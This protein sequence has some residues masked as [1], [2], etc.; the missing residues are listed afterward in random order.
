MRFV[1][2]LGS[3]ALA[4]VITLPVY[5]QLNTDANVNQRQAGSVRGKVIDRDGKPIQNA[6]IRFDNQT[7]HQADT[8]KTNKSGDYSIVGLLAGS[9]KAYLFVDGK[10]VMVK[11]EGVGNQIL[12]NDVT[13]TRVNFD[14]KD[15]PTTRVEAPGAPSAA[16]LNAKEKAAAEKKNIEEVKNSYAAGLAAMKA[17]NFEEAIKL[18]QVAADKDPG[19]SAVFANMGVSYA[20]L[21]KYDDAIAAYQKS[22]AIKPDDPSIHALLSLALANNGKIDE[23]TQSA[24]EVAKLDPAMAGQSYYNLGAILANRGK[25]KEAVEVFKKAIEVD[26]KNAPSYYQIGIAYFGTPD[27]IPQGI[28]AFEKYLQLMPNGP[29]AETAKQFIAAGKAQGK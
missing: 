9:Y 4:A 7:T 14:M 8:A 16:S 25:F 17:N 20:N 15:A 24:Q 2:R 21:K 1:A 3:V 18:F 19:Q 11:G 10:P 13:D 23:A 26:P 6:Q 29:D 12:I 22:L 27:T 5:A 28:A